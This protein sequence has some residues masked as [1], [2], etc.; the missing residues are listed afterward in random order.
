MV[1]IQNVAGDYYLK[2]LDKVYMDLYNTKDNSIPQKTVLLILELL[3]I[4]I[5]YW[6]L[7]A[8][9]YNQLFSSDSPVHGNEMRHMILFT[10]NLIVFF[11]MCI[12]IF[13]FVKRHIPWEE[14][15]SI[16]VAFT[17]YYIGFA[18]LGYKVTSDIELVDIFGITLFLIGSFL[19]TGSELLR[20]KWKKNSAN[21]GKLYTVGFFK[22]SMHINYFGDVL[23]VMGY[24]LVTRN[25]YSIVIP[26]LLFCFFTLY[27]I[28]KLDN[29]LASRYGQQFAE[30]RR[31]TK[32]LVPFIY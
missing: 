11:R 28:P 29:Y 6:I 27:N 3:I 1:E 16:P 22:Y 14:A 20:D 23:W 25:W 7:L 4:G 10:F 17:V 12:T 18:L 31:I 5:S 24:A 21:K 30:Y 15:F 9:G 13:Y 32:K 2:A 8:E 19:N 26:I